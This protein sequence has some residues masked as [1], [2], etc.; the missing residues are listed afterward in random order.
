MVVIC[1]FL[2]RNEIE[3]FFIC[4]LISCISLFVM[5]LL[6]TLAHFYQVVC[7]LIL[8]VRFLCIYYT[9]HE[10]FD[11]CIFCDA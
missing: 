8:V 4:L 7:L 5:F 9:R 2:M 11:R 6:K 10:S 3:H 1:I